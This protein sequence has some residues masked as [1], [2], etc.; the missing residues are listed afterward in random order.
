MTALLPV[1]PL[2]WQI[3]VICDGS[4]QTIGFQLYHDGGSMMVNKKEIDAA[5]SLWLSSVHEVNQENK[6]GER[7]AKDNPRPSVGSAAQPPKKGEDKE[8]ILKLSAA[9]QAKRPL[10]SYTSDLERDFEW[11]VPRDLLRTF[12]LKAD[13]PELLRAGSFGVDAYSGGSTQVEENVQDGVKT[14][15]WAMDFRGSLKIM[16]AQDLFSLFMTAVARKLPGPVLGGVDELQP[17]MAV[18][19]EDW[20]KFKLR[21]N[22]LSQ[23]V[24]DIHATGLGTLGEIYAR[25]V[26][27]L[28]RQQKLPGIDK[29]VEWARERAEEYA[30]LESWERTQEALEWLSRIAQTPSTVARAQGILMDHLRRAI[31]IIKFREEQ[32]HND[33]LVAL[34]QLRDT[35]TRKLEDTT[36]ARQHLKDFN[37][38]GL[39]RLFQ[40]CS[41]GE[42]QPLLPLTENI[43]ARKS[44]QDTCA[45]SMVY[46]EIF[47]VTGLHYEALRTMTCGD[48]S[49]PGLKNGLTD[50]ELQELLKRHVNARDI[51][52]RTPAHYATG[53]FLIQSLKKFG[54]DLNAKDLLHWTPLH[55]ACW[56]ENTL[57][58][59]LLIQNGV[60]LDH[61]TRDG[62]TPLHYAA[63]QGSTEGVRMLAEAGATID[64][65]DYQG[66]APIHLAAYRGC[67][68]IVSTLSENGSRGIRDRFGRTALHQAA[69]SGSMELMDVLIIDD[70]YMEAKD[71]N[72]QT[73]LSLAARIGHSDSV[74]K[75]LDKGA[76]AES[77][78]Q[79]GRTPL[80]WAARLGHLKCVE[81]LL[82]KG[83]DVESK[84]QGG[85]TPLHWAVITG[86][87]HCVEKLLEKGADA[88]STDFP[89]QR[90]L[91]LA[92]RSGN[93]DIVLA[94][95]EKKG[96]VNSKIYE[97]GWTPL[98]SAARTGRTDILEILVDKGADTH[99]TDKV[100]MTA[101]HHAAQG[102]HSGA[103]EIL[104]K[105][106]GDKE[107]RAGLEEVTALMMAV[108]HRSF[109]AARQLL[110][111]GADVKATG[112]K[113]ETAMSVAM[114][115]ATQ[116][117]I[118]LLQYYQ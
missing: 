7:S 32:K 37:N 106:G 53:R 93:S 4:K 29:V 86:H 30:R 67:S 70:I 110:E 60:G 33:T 118:D 24:Q 96:D 81:K 75:F 19:G 108:R 10:E 89:G 41:C 56:T 55:Y 111:S 34:T 47:H 105:L 35:L 20:K 43:R 76:D 63:S 92:A 99:Q 90:P 94:L 1:E 72:G 117:M 17:E 27:P 9:F 31:L 102:D 5:L 16:C 66:N 87:L 97:T 74:E 8:P 40:H 101:L 107:A 22:K 109:N 14:E 82:E 28:S 50:Q 98:M 6:S 15:V 65:R 112:K 39:V 69:L 83:V 11:W 59:K 26:T 52:D 12:R 51:L 88:G 100:G 91:H 113:G 45:R 57:A 95:L 18:G 103:V 64:I 115:F 77:K 49:H 58:T 44:N 36:N 3:S 104:I 114:E 62:S 116:E 48:W 80:H 73:P 79:G 68:Q 42:R 38:A 2:E 23:M 54:A 78:D 61:Q 21:N 46:P 25:V 13:D 85:R 71:R 84:D